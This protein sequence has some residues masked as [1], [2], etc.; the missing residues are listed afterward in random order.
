M[1]I[2]NNKIRVKIIARGQDSYPWAKQLPEASSSI[3]NCE[4]VF[5]KDDP[6]YD[7]LVVI[8]DVSRNYFSQPETLN[9]PK[10]HTLLVTSE[11]PTIT[12]Y[13]DAFCSQFAKVLTSHPEMLYHI[14]VKFSVTLATFGLMGIILMTVGKRF[15]GINLVQFQ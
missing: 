10:E 4:Y 7:W 15:I 2:I 8:D 6:V 9:C 3:G 13:G 11:P 5:A 1:P 14:L 12:N